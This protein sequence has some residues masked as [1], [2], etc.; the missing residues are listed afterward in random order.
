MIPIVELGLQAYCR[1]APYL[2]ITEEANTT[3][4]HTDAIILSFV[5]CHSFKR[6][7]QLPLVLALSVSRFLLAPSSQ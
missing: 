7:N 6:A 3:C 5:E 4:H 2:Q 1:A